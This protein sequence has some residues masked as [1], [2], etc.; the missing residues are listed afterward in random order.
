MALTIVDW[1]Y[2]TSGYTTDSSST[3]FVPVDTVTGT[4]APRGED[5]IES[6]CSISITIPWTGT[7]GSTSGNL[8]DDWIVSEFAAFSADLDFNKM[9]I[10]PESGE[11]ENR[12]WDTAMKL[13]R[14]KYGLLIDGE[15]VL[16]GQ[17]DAQK[18]YP[19]GYGV[20]NTAASVEKY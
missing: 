18:A 17:L 8:V 14:A 7:N 4:Y 5:L 9:Y 15:L 16:P 11:M 10:D 1:F 2:S 3:D 6:I 19:H 12:H 13:C 20:D